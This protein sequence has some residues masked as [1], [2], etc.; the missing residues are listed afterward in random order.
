[1]GVGDYTFIG[2]GTSVIQQCTL[3]HHTMVAAGSMVIGD[4]PS[5]VMVAGVPA[6]LKKT[7]PQRSL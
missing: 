3:G 2:M 5:Y 6:I 7:L 1:V 4:I